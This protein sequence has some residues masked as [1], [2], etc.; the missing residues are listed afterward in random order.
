MQDCNIS[1]F[2]NHLSKKQSKIST[3]HTH[4]PF[5]FCMN[6]ST[7]LQQKLDNRLAVVA[8]SKMQRCWMAAVKITTVDCMTVSC[9]KFLY[10]N[11]PT[12]QNAINLTWST[13]ILKIQNKQTYITRIHLNDS[14]PS[15]VTSLR[16]IA[17]QLSVWISCCHCCCIT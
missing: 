14:P 16:H 4:I 8:S 3:D 6:I 15:D 5:V 12:S 10:K 13:T 11:S 17:V 1:V 2:D 9:H 7:M